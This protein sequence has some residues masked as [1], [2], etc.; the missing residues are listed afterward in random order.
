MDWSE[1][2]QK[3]PL[4]RKSLLYLLQISPAWNNEDWVNYNTTSKLT[5]PPSGSWLVDYMYLVLVGPFSWVPIILSLTAVNS[6]P[7][8]VWQKWSSIFRSIFIHLV[9]ESLNEFGSGSKTNTVSLYT[10]TCILHQLR[11]SLLFVESRGD[12]LWAQRPSLTETVDVR[13]HML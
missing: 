12:P 10:Y 2:S 9:M 13:S 7:Q 11:M 6:N 4:F 3:A 1:A 8:T 5:Q